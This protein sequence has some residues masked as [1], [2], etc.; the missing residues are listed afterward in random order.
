MAT[1]ALLRYLRV[2]VA[3]AAAIVMRV[4]TDRPCPCEF[5]RAHRQFVRDS[6]AAYRAEVRGLPSA[7]RR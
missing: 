7:G 1:L 5:C 4:I 6:A 2:I 3:G